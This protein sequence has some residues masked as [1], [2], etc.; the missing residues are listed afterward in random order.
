[1]N[2]YLCVITTALVVTQIIRLAQNVISLYKQNQLINKQ[3]NQIEDI[4]QEDLENQRLAYKMIVEYL[5][6]EE[7]EVVLKEAQK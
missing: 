2:A 5:T 1:M 3:L 7:A 4:T 6:R